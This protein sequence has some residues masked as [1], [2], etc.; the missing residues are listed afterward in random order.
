[1]P[2]GNDAVLTLRAA[3]VSFVV[4]TTGRVPRVLHWGAD[5]GPTDPTVEGALRASAGPALLN[6]SPDVV[7]DFSLWPTESE[8]WTGMPAQEGHASG[9]ETTPRPELHRFSYEP[10]ADAGGAMSFELTDRV[11]ALRGTITIALDRFG[12]LSVTRSVQ[13]D[14]ALNPAASASPYALDAL[15]NL[16][17]LPDRAVD[18]LDF[19]G[20]WVRERSPQRGAIMFGN[21]LRRSRRGKPGHDSPYLLVAGTADLGFGRGEAW[22]THLAWSGDAEYFIERLPEGAGS[23]SSALG[24]GEALRVGEILLEDGERHDAP[25]AL[26]V[27]SDRG[28]DGLADRLHRRLRA[29]PRHPTSTRPLTLNTWEAVYFDHDIVRL[30]DLVDRAERV[31]VERVVLDDGWFHGRRADDAGLG[32]WVVDGDVWP[33]GLGPLVDLVHSHGMQFG[34]WFEPEMINLDSD[35]ARDHPEWI[36]GPSQGLGAPARNQYVL[37]IAVPEAWQLVLERV[38]ALVSEYS[39]DYIKW[40]HTRALSE[41]IGRRDGV[42]RPVVHEQIVALYRMLDELR[43]RHPKLEIE[44]CSGGGGRVDLGILDRTDRLWASDCN[45]PVE[46]LT[47]ERWTRMLVPPELIGSHLGAERSHTT[48]RRTDLSFRLAVALT[49]HAGIEWDLQEASDEELQRI[50][51]WAASYRELR[52]LIHS[53]RVVNADLADDATSLTG[54]VA[55]DGGRAL[56][57][58]ARIATS[59]AGQSG[60]VRFPGV[61]PAARYRVRVRREFGDAARHENADPAWVTAACCTGGIELPGSV[62]ALAGV[63]LPTLDPQQ[64]MIFDLERV[65]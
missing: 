10:D 52:G 48:S 55:H 59:A 38:S 27:W 45:D 29:R 5:L 46:R 9:A 8:G 47:I 21:H 41:P 42:D 4:D 60:R 7:R 31:G 25:T 17:P 28:L 56:Y 24:V 58:W 37:D 64:A 36:L 32:D 11:T 39:I 51:A 43:A 19:S 61:E 49:A 62:L 22:A 34:L 14:L 12:V 54:I 23:F 33:S 1:M 26:F 35:L 44:T 20:K 30:A 40:D 6:N 2:D 63:P 16:M 3:G 57:T 18:I 53:G 13:R 15:R 50:T 65:S